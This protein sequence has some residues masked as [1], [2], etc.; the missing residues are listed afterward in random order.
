[1]KLLA[2]AGGFEIVET[3]FDSTAFQFWGSEQVR[4]GIPLHDPRSVHVRGGNGGFTGKEMRSY[5]AKAEE[6]NRAGD[7][8]QACF[9]LRRSTYSPNSTGAST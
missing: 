8:D 6:L 2:L 4:R 7:G 5:T 3:K 1:M 9:Y